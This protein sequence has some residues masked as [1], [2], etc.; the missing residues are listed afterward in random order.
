MTTSDKCK[1]GAHICFKYQNHPLS[2][3]FKI[4]TKKRFPIQP[5]MLQLYQNLAATDY[6]SNASHVT[7]CPVVKISNLN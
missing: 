6:K 3:N 5:K 4:L 1:Q 2:V 7:P